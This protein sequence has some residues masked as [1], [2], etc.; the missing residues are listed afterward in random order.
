MQKKKTSFES[1]FIYIMDI[2]SSKLH[3]WYFSDR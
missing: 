2:L 3:I 1:L